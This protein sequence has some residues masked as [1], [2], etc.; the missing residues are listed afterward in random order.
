MNNVT[1][2]AIL[3]RETALHTRS[4]IKKCVCMAQSAIKT[5]KLTRKTGNLHYLVYTQVRVI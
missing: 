2:K 3:F 4:T 1:H 5:A